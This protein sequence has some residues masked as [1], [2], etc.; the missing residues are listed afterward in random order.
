MTAAA[1]EWILWYYGSRVVDI[2]IQGGEYMNSARIRLFL[3]SSD[4]DIVNE[5]LPSFPTIF[6]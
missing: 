1:M 6:T 3:I 4:Y 5:K 2:H